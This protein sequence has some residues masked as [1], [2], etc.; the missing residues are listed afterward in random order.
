MLVDVENDVSSIDVQN[1]GKLE[2]FNLVIES[3]T[4]V[5]DKDIDII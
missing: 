2:E 5:I 4:E 1:S 3:L